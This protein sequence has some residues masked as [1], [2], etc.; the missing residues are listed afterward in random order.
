MGLIGRVLSYVYGQLGQNGDTVADIKLDTGGEA[1]TTAWQAE[2][3]GQTSQP[4]PSDLVVVVPIPG[5]GR[6]VA[7]A[8]ID[9]NNPQDIAAGEHK[10]YAR[11]GSGTIVCHV[12]LKND[13]SID[14]TS[15]ADINVNGATITPTGDITSPGTITAETIIGNS[16]VQA[17][18]KELAEH[19]HNQPNDSGGN[20]ESPTGPN[21]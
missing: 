16:S 15:T 9:P 13:G 7:V 11:D 21:N 19:N 4:L 6:Q 2:P 10:T 14:I 17:A 3:A 8:F 1:N 5:Q 12:H 18:G 20:T